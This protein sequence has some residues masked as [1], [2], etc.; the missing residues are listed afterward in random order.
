YIL[1][2]TNSGNAPSPSLVVTDRYDQGLEHEKKANP[3]QNSLG[4]IQPGET[5]KV[6]ITFRVTR[7]GRLCHT[8]EVA[9][10]PG[11]I[12]ETKQICLNVAGEPPPREQPAMSLNIAT[13]QK[14][15]TVGNR[16]LFT[17]DVANTGPTPARQ[18]QI[19]AHFDQQLHVEQATPGAQRTG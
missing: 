4:V 2:V 11:N 17:I 16:P 7:T 14:T 12:R 8:V 1:E 6:G 19:V 9:G 5:K 18:V 10:E 15:Y 13:P 3:L